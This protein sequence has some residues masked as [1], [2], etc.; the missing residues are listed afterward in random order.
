MPVQVELGKPA[1]AFGSGARSS[2]S[3][4]SRSTCRYPSARGHLLCKQ[5]TI[6]SVSRIT[7]QRGATHTQLARNAYPLKVIEAAKFHVADQNYSRSERF[8]QKGQTKSPAPSRGRISAPR[9][10]SA[11]GSRTN[12]RTRRP[13]RAQ[14]GPHRNAMGEL[15]RRAG[16]TSSGFGAS[17]RLGTLHCSLH[18]EKVLSVN[19]KKSSP[20]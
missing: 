19:Q 5:A 7:V 17:R 20:W 18:V 1:I 4:A 3:S 13:S 16:R 14:P 10:R 15:R 11:D 9:V 12:H 8:S 2:W 6:R